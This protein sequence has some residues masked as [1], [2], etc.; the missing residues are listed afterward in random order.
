MEKIVEELKLL[1]KDF[2]SHK[3]KKPIINNK[4]SLWRRTTNLA[5]VSKEANP[6]VKV[7]NV[8]HSDWTGK[9]GMIIE[10]SMLLPERHQAYYEYN[11]EGDSLVVFPIFNTTIPWTMVTWLPAIAGCKIKVSEKGL[12]LWPEPYIGKNWHNLKDYGVKYNFDWLDK[13]KEF[14]KY[15]VEKGD[16]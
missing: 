2:W 10:P 11:N 6:E 9:G 13:L 14:T 5:N 12:T 1:H 3:L 15:L 4:Y 7:H 16:F 8:L